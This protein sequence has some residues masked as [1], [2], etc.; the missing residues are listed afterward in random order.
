MYFV[1]KQECSAWNNS[2]SRHRSNLRNN[3]FYIKIN[4]FKQGNERRLL[5]KIDF[6]II[7][8]TLAQVLNRCGFSHLTGTTQQQGLMS[9]TGRP[10]R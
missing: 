1:K 9:L 6:H 8:K 4:A 7:L 3:L 5:L 2:C 10:F